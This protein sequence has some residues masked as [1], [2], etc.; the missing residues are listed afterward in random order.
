LKGSPRFF[1]GAV[2][3]PGS[4]PLEPQIAKMEKKVRVGAKF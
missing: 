2:V 1:A 4:N 3:S